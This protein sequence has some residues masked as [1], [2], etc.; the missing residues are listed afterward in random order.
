VERDAVLPGVLSEMQVEFDIT[1][2]RA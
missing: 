2:A 1:A